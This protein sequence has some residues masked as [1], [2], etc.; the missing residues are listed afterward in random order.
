MQA[1]LT[2]R[3]WHRLVR[4]SNPRP[5]QG[6]GEGFLSFEN[7]EED[8]CNSK[9]NP[10]VL[11][12]PK[13]QQQ[14]CARVGGAVTVI[15]SAHKLALHIS[16]VCGSAGSPPV[17]SSTQRD[18]VAQTAAIEGTHTKTLFCWDCEE[19]VSR[20]N[21]CERQN[22]ISMQGSITASGKPLAALI[23]ASTAA[24]TLHDK[25]PDALSYSSACR[26]RGQN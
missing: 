2:Q 23:S 22:T 17:Q 4:D 18:E 21:V 20:P 24:L 6:G 1:C 26:K 13:G 5:F 3:Y 10:E 12:A 14:C 15:C 8:N 7:M 19:P 25:V 16:S 9:I 11:Q